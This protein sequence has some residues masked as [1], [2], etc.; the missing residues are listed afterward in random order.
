MYL[1]QFLGHELYIA[2]VIFILLLGITL[3]IKIVS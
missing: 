2:I 3:L 1:E